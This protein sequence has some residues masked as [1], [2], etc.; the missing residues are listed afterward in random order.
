MFHFCLLLELKWRFLDRLPVSFHKFLD[1]MLRQIITISTFFFFSNTVLPQ[2]GKYDIITKD[3]LHFWEAVDSLKENCDTTQIF[4]RHV[5]DRATDEFKIFIKQWK[6]TAKDYTYQYRRYPNFY[7]TL[8][9]NTLKLINDENLIRQTINNFRKIYPNYVDATICI[10]LGN[11]RTGGTISIIQEGILKHNKFAYIGLE[12][13]GLD[14][15]TII[16]ELPISIQDYVSRSNFYRTIIHELVHVQQETHGY[17]IMEAYNGNNLAAAI[18]KEGIPDFISKLVYPIGNDGDHYK[19]GIQHEEILRA[20]LKNEIYGSDFTYWIYNS[21]TVTD[22]PR[23]L[24]Y[25]M[26]SRIANSYFNQ[27]S[28]TTLNVTELIEIKN[29]KKFIKKSKYFD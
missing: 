15:S 1:F 25:F 21:N 14:S 9:S 5:I 20:K 4:Q 8:K 6:I 11:F 28:E 23:D 7:R 18:L 12:F 13:H 3:V 22:Q 16:S 10:S 26:G 2:N 27:L 24:G 29:V 17:K 19:Y